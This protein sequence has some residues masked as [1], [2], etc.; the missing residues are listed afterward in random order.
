MSINHTTQSGNL[1][2]DAELK[3]LAN[4]TAVCNFTIAVNE[5]T[6]RGDEW[7]DE[8][9]FFDVEVWGKPAEWA[10]ELRKGEGVTV[11]G[12]LKQDKWEKDGV[13]QSRV[14]IKAFDVVPSKGRGDATSQERAERPT[15]YSQSAPA[16][17]VPDEDIPF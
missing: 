13:K 1:V 4:N 15:E 9:N 11:D 6:K 10:G 12:K 2:R 17:Q 8:V 14:K 16:K 7:I 3:Y 5:R